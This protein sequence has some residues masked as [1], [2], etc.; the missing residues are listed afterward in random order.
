MLYLYIFRL[1]EVL[2]KF[3]AINFSKIH[4][5]IKLIKFGQNELQVQVS[6]KN[7]NEHIFTVVF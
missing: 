5:L 4:Y 7:L 6:I 2:L 3:K 1:T